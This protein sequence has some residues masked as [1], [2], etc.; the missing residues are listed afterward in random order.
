MTLVVDVAASRGPHSLHFVG[1]ESPAAA[2]QLFCARVGQLFLS[3]RYERQRAKEYLPLN[4]KQ[5]LCLRLYTYGCDCYNNHLVT[6]IVDVA[7]SRNSQI[8]L[9]LLKPV[10]HH[11][12][13]NST[14]VTY[15][16]GA[17]EKKTWDALFSL[18]TD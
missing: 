12:S 17:A 18:Q 6:L 2:G 7:A 15:S 3:A 14:A 11:G 13:R 8:A 5:G 1:K 10:W 16:H 4:I 9:L